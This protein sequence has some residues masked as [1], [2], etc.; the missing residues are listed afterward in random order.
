MRRIS[1]E[2]SKVVVALSLVLVLQAC[3]GTDSPVPAE[4]QNEEVKKEKEGVYTV[5]SMGEVI[6]QMEV[7]LEKSGTPNKAGVRK[8]LIEFYESYG[9]LFSED[10]LA[11][12]MLFKAGNQSVN[13]EKFTEA[14][15]F[16]KSVEDKYS[17]YQKRPECIYL[18]GFIYDSYTSQYGKAKAKYEQLI[19]EYPKHVLT[20]QAKMSIENLGLSDEEIIRKFEKQN[21]E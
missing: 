3:G 11:P 14:L 13:L 8:T 17:R 19:Q 12:D 5:A 7:D 15:R 16:Y 20:E 6:T 18:Q 21:A 9:N 1:L 4:I 2:L 10:K